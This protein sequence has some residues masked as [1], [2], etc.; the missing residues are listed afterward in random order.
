MQA[1]LEKKFDDGITRDL[2]TI[3]NNMGTGIRNI[4]GE[5]NEDNKDKE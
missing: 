3:L 4:E 1:N 2:M 5:M